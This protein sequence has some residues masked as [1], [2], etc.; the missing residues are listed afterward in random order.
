LLATA[1]P[2]ENPVADIAARPDVRPI[3]GTYFVMVSTIE[4][5]K[6]HWMLLHIWRRSDCW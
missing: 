2:E 4:P 5:R 6:N 3:E 1:L